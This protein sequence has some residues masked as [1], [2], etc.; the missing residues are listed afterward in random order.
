MKPIPI[1]QIYRQVQAHPIGLAASEHGRHAIRATSS[2]ERAILC[3]RMLAGSHTWS[4]GYERRLDD[5]FEMND[6]AAV[7]GWLIEFAEADERIA[8]LINE[9]AY[10]KMKGTTILDYWIGLG[11]RLAHRRTPQLTL[12]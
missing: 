8:L 6:G 4:D 10:M 5:C 2:Y 3:L 11:D 9:H 7:A 12:L 1:N